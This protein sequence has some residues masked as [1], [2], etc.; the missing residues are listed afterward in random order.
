LSL[1]YAETLPHRVAG[2]ILR[3][4]FLA[5]ARDLAWFAGGG[6]NRLLPDAWARF[7]GF[8]DP[9]RRHELVSAYYD[10]VRGDDLELARSA[11]RHWL[12]WAGAL[13]TWPTDIEVRFGGLDPAQAVN[14]V[15]VETHYASHAYFIRENQ[16]LEEVQRIPAVPVT[17]IHGRRDVTCT[18]DASWELHECLP[19]AR[20]VIVPN[21][22]HLA[23]EP[24]MTSALVQATDEM[25]GL[26]A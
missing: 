1:L 6:A 12:A 3:G 4:S 16:I 20:L 5:R 17:L 11:A 8:I 26:L 13:V 7:R 19:A 10:C 22:G 21:G 2:M 9:A 25:A 14:E 18:L 15:M 23:S 24:V